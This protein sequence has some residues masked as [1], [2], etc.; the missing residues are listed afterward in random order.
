MDFLFFSL[1]V[2]PLSFCSL[3]HD[4]TPPPPPPRFYGKNSVTL[5]SNLDLCPELQNHKAIFRMSPC[6]CCHI[7]CITHQHL[8]G[9]TNLLFLF[10]TNKNAYFFSLNLPLLLVL[11]GISD[12]NFGALLNFILSLIHYIPVLINP[13]TTVS[14]VPWQCSAFTLI[15]SFLEPSALSVALASHFLISSFPKPIYPPPLKSSY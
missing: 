3:S 5:V 12:Q 2:I 4:S 6:E 13:T 8:Q 7:L 15:T 11:S 9:R 14:L 1:S 10:S